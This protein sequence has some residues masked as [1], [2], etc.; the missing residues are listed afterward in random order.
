M[1]VRFP[2]EAAEVEVNEGE[3]HH[4]KLCRSSGLLAVK[5]RGVKSPPS[6]AHMLGLLAHAPVSYSPASPRPRLRS[7]WICATAADLDLIS[8]SLPFLDDAALL[9]DDCEYSGLGSSFAGS[10]EC[11]SAAA[12]WRSALPQ[13]LPN[14]EC[15][16]KFALPADA[17]GVV[18]CR[19]KIAFDAPVPPAVLPGQRRRLEAA[20]LTVSADGRTRVTA[21]VVGTLALD[22]ESGRV[23]RISE[24]L[25]GD[26]LAVE[27]SIA[28]FELLNARAVAR[29]PEALPPPAREPLA[30]W[31]ALR[32]M[33]RIELEELR[34]REREQSDELSVLTDDAGVTDDDF[35]AS[36]R[37][38]LLRIFLLGAAGPLAVY[39]FAK[40]LRAVV[41]AG[42]S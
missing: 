12:L 35:E 25:V 41:T 7:S 5:V 23:R 21:S 33:M 16:A 15:T 30:Y 34:R 17:R 32:G 42:L 8:E 36:F 24:R 1:L 9:S 37:A 39:V 6:P 22:P 20:R 26:P 31:D 3:Q 13:R 18:S 28:H 27:T 29:L 4:H 14:F 2:E 11:A 40:V 10:A 19:Y 38:Y